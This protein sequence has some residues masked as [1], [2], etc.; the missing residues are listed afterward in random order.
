MGKVLVNESSLTAIAKAIRNNGTS[1]STK[2]KPS[3]M[4]EGVTMACMATGQAA[5]NNGLDDGRIQGREAEAYERD[6]QDAAYLA[7]INVKFQTYGAANA[8]TL[9]DVPQQIDEVHAIG[10]EQGGEN[11][12][13]IPDEAFVLEDV[14]KYKFAYD[15]WSWFFN[16]Y[17]DKLT[18][19][20]LTNLEYAFAVSNQLESFP[21]GFVF[22][23]KSNSTLNCSAAFRESPFVSVPSL[24]FKQT[25]GTSYTVN[26]SYLFIHCHELKS[27]GNL[28]NANISSLTSLFGN[29][30]K[31]RQLPNFI[32]VDFDAIHNAS[33]SLSGIFENCYSLRNID[34][35]LLKEL[36]ASKV[37]TFVS[38]LFY[39][40]FNN[41]Y[42]LDE[43]IGM[44]P[45]TGTVTSN[46]FSNTFTNC[47]RLKNAIFT[48]QA[49]GTPYTV[50]WKT[51]T[52]DLSKYVGYANG[53]TNITK[54][55]SGITTSKQVTSATTYQAL[56]NDPDWFT[57]NIAYSRYNHD[58]AVATI[59]SL[60]DA[61]AYLST[62]S[63]TNTIKFKGAAGS[64]TD[65]GAINT[66]TAEE[67]AVATAKGWTVTLS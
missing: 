66:L 40:L 29:C 42:V 39:N 60:P 18:T 31:L 4:A 62:T 55:N 43:A 36:Y 21:D 3:E 25:A 12:D 34:S 65:G 11:G 57:T 48:T 5:Y 53:S 67:I 6:K 22:N 46:A 8:N 32:N 45:I 51:Q 13:S 2:Y 17:K 19:K 59:N 9:E 26:I 27:I 14:I 37:T 1:S 44:T 64:S 47:Y 49:D 41:C 50:N 63:G 16:N 28:K 58:S 52:I 61:S 30:Y 23:F 10:V 56:K 15:S 35:D 38:V 7:A 54:Y 33:S 24:D 20:D